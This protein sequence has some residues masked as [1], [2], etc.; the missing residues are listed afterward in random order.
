[1]RWARH[2]GWTVQRLGSRRVCRERSQLLFP[3]PSFLVCKM[4]TL[5]ETRV[6]LW[7]KR[8]LHRLYEMAVSKTLDTRQWE[9]ELRGR[10][11]TDGASPRVAPARALERFLRATVWSRAR[12]EPPCGEAREL[13]VRGSRGR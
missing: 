5:T 11:E 10:Q 7:D 2:Q 9:A 1:M 12:A 13:Q 6:T 8:K 4:E 3:S